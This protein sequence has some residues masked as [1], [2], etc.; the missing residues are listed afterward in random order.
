MISLPHNAIPL[1]ACSIGDPTPY[2]VAWVPQLMSDLCIKDPLFVLD[3]AL[4]HSNV[5]LILGQHYD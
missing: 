3:L 1:H 2:M 4:Q 5:F